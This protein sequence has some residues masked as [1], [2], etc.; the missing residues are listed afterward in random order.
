[1]TFTT[2]AI[3]AGGIRSPNVYMI[4]R[5]GR[6]GGWDVRVNM[7]TH[8]IMVAARPIFDL[9]QAH[10]NGEVQVMYPKEMNIKKSSA[11]VIRK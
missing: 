10:S 1:M 8:E 9:S 4:G 2:M 7:K 6:I 11:R 3:V 5:N